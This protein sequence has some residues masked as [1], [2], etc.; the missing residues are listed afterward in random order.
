MV[1]KMKNILLVFSLI[2]FSFSYNGVAICNDCN[3]A[4]ICQT[5]ATG[6][7]GTLNCVGNTCHCVSSSGSICGGPIER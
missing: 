2:V 5:G 6:T 4:C 7:T 1:M 3:E